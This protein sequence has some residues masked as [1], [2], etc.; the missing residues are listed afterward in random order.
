[1]PFG[2][3]NAPATFQVY[4]N[5]AMR[6]ILNEFVVVYLDNILIYSQNEEEHVRHVQEVLQHLEQHNLFAKLSKCEFHKQDIHFLGLHVGANSV[7][8]DSDWVATI[9]DWLMLESFH[10]IQV[11]LGFTGFFCQFIENYAKITA[12]LT[13]LLQGM[14]Q[15]KKKGPFCL[16]MEGH[17]AFK[18]LKQEFMEPPV[19]KHFDYHLPTLVVTDVSQ[20]TVAAILL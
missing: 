2:L 1:M 9:Q 15:E 4:I 7:S 14:E 18:H 19:L 17:Q 8:M 3:C 6:G 11:F 5:Q 20:Y 13:D 16:M 10:N 12:P